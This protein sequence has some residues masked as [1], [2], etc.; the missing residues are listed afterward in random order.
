MV[1]WRF[2][3]IFLLIYHYCISPSDKTSNLGIGLQS[4]YTFSLSL[5]QKFSHIYYVDF[6]LLKHPDMKWLICRSML[7]YWLTWECCNHFHLIFRCSQTLARAQTSEREFWTI[8]FHHPSISNTNKTMLFDKRQK[9]KEMF[10]M[11]PWNHKFS[12]ESRQKYRRGSWGGRRGERSLKLFSVALP[13]TEEDRGCWHIL[14]SDQRL[15]PSWNCTPVVFV[16]SRPIHYIKRI[17][18]LSKVLTV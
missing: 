6:E 14:F 1:Q 4:F 11:F 13:G 2:L 18:V 3:P 10:W 8:R 5:L 9:E 15:V 17:C 12:D 7:W 16:H